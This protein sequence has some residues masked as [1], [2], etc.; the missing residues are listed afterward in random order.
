[1]ILFPGESSSV[2]RKSLLVSVCVFRPRAG[3]ETLGGDGDG[4][5]RSLPGAGGPAG[6]P[7]GGAPPQGHGGEGV[8]SAQSHQLPAGEEGG[9]TM[10]VLPPLRLLLLHPSFSLLPS[11]EFLFQISRASIHLLL[12]QQ[13]EAVRL[14][15]QLPSNL[16]REDVEETLRRMEEQLGDGVRACIHGRP[17]FHHLADVPD[18][19]QEAEAQLRRSRRSCETKQ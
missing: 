15:R 11:C 5:R 19:Q 6:D 12:H 10:E 3:P 14:A 4:R 17:F 7:D 18:S 16:S 2:W 8:S 9:K 13:G 1:M